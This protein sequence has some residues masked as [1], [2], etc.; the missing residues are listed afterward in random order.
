MTQ[1]DEIEKMVKECHTMLLQYMKDN[2]SVMYEQ[3]DPAIEKARMNRIKNFS[4][5]P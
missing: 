1:L 2:H 4:E 3:D 5:V